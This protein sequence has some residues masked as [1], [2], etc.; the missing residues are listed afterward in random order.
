MG[1]VV[2]GYGRASTDKQ[3]LSTEQQEAK[4]VDAFGAYQ[5][6]KPE[7]EFAAWGGFF[8]DQ[9]VCRETYFRQREAGSQILALSSPGDIILV[10]NYDRI[11]ANVRDVCE[12]LEIL[13][14]AKVGLVILDCQIDTTTIIGEFCFKLMALV[15]ELDVKTIR[16]RCRNHA[17]YRKRIGRPI[18]GVCTIGWR[19]VSVIVPGIEGIQKYLV[20]H[21]RARRLASEITMIAEGLNGNKLAA[22]RWCNRHKLFNFRGRRWNPETFN[23]WLWAAKANFPLPN[24]LQEAAPIPPNALPVH[25]STIDNED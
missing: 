22:M 13:R 19:I 16:E 9:A 10:S 12:T 21:K 24:G 14:D 15:K 23:Q 3:V 17:A 5:K 18:S 4:V 8:R 6:I 20:P 2:R 25:V 11:F 1:I 7:W